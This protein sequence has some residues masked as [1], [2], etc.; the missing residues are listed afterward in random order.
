[1]NDWGVILRGSHFHLCHRVKMCANCARKPNIVSLPI[2]L[3]EPSWPP[4]DI[5]GTSA[6]ACDITTKHR[7]SAVP[8]AD[9]VIDIAGSSGKTQL[10]SFVKSLRC[11]RRLRD[12]KYTRDR[13]LYKAMAALTTTIVTLRPCK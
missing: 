10:A 1:M 13:T 7:G 12:E 3:V 4:R 9:S 2:R 11:R 5:S 8:T 6:Q